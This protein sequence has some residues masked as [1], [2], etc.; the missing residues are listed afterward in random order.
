MFV[1]LRTWAQVTTGQIDGY[2]F[3]PSHRPVPHA[4]VVA[5]HAERVFAR[6]VFTDAAGFYQLTALPPAVYTVT[7]S[8]QGFAP[9]TAPASRLHVNSRLRVD[10][11]LA[12]A[13]APRQIQFAARIS[14]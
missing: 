11:T 9:A 14:F 3:D 2:V 6:T 10:V 8:A 4:E 7:A 5:R 12:L 1:A 13:K